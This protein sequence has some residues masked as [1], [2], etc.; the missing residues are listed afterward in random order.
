M[1]QLKLSQAQKIINNK[2]HL[3]WH[4][5]N[6]QNLSLESI[7]EAVLNFGSWED[8]QQLKK[9]LGTKKLGDIYQKIRNKKRQNLKAITANYFDKYFH[10]HARSSNH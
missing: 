5:K 7:T 10:K 8:F 4:T 6:Y 1:K 9:I 3:I 2:P